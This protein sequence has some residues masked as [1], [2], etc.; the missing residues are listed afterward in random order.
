[1]PQDLRAD[2][3]G[4]GELRCGRDVA[5]DGWRQPD[6]RER[7]AGG[8]HQNRRRREPARFAGE[9]FRSVR[10][11]GHREDA[12][13]RARTRRGVSGHADRAVDRARLG[14]QQVPVFFD[15]HGDREERPVPDEY[16]IARRRTAGRRANS[17]QGEKQQTCLSPRGTF[18][19]GRFCAAR[20]GT[21][22]AA[23]GCDDSGRDGAGADS[24]DAEAA[25]RRLLRAARHG[26]RLLGS[27]KGRR[28]RR[29]ASLQLEAAGAVPQSDG[30][31]QRPAF[32]VGRTASGRDRR[33]P[34]GRR[35]VPVREQA[36]ED[37]R[38]RR[39]RRHDD[40]SDHRA[41]DRHA[42]T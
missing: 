18:P 7:R 30:D 26:A 10:A 6:R 35:R 3:T 25:V 11:R 32:A 34:L 15:R 29:R 20:G 27:R 12:D 16:E 36:E 17:D 24:R 40:R 37:R 31:L 38:R 19:G 28:A 5:H 9:A 33:G 4:A 2:R 1:M 41:E 8:R 14:R 42:R 23:A 22:A 13:L 21:R 39:L